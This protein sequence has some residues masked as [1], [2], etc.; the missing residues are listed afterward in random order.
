MCNYCRQMYKY[1]MNTVKAAKKRE[2]SVELLY[3][4]SAFTMFLMPVK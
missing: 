4:M 3:F 1:T 2:L